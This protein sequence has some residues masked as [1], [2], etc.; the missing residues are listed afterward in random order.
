V[1]NSGLVLGIVLVLVSASLQVFSLHILSIC[2]SKVEHPSFYTVCQA[3][4]PRL[5][6]LVD[7]AVVLQSFGICTSYLIVISDLMPDVMDNFGVR[8]G[9]WQDRPVWVLLGFA[10][11]APLSC[12]RKL[13]ALRYTSG[14]SVLFVVF[15]MLMVLCF[16][17][18]G[19]P[20]GWGLHPCE[21]VLSLHQPV[22]PLD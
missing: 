6:F 10:L 20:L 5:T 1:A 16:S 2:A 22:V 12:F 4:V 15:L 9:F 17:L 3:S 19:D 18:P 7:F 13:D 21:V 8:E 11:C 14:L